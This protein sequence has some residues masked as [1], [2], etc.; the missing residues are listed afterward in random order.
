MLF[1]AN[2][3]TVTHVIGRFPAAI[4]RQS[5]VVGSDAKRYHDEQEVACIG[6][7]SHSL[8]RFTIGRT[9]EYSS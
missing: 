1:R 6:Y 7:P 2:R 8:A 4:E 5:E 3:Q 9:S